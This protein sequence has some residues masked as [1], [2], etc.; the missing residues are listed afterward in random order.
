MENFVKHNH[1]NENRVIRWIADNATDLF[2]GENFPIL[3]IYT[4]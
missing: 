4:Y 2:N 1:I 3:Y